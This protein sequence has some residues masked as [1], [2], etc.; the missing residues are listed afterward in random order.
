MSITPRQAYLSMFDALDAAWDER[1]TERLRTFL[2]ESNPHLWRDGGS[3][4]PAVFADFSASFEKSAGAGASPESALDFVHRYLEGQN[5][6]YSW[7][8][9]DLVESFDS[10]VIPELWAQAIEEN[11]EQ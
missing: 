1:Q 6:E 11:A 9:G 5:E 7:E 2:S 10:V 8:K 3:A 4:D